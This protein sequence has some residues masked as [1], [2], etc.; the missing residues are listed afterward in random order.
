M[1]QPQTCKP[2][3]APNLIT[4]QPGGVPAIGQLER[5]W[6]SAVPL[7]QHMAVVA[8]G[9]VKQ[10][11]G[12][13]PQA[14]WAVEWMEEFSVSSSWG[15]GSRIAETAGLDTSATLQ[16][17]KHIGAGTAADKAGTHAGKATAA[18]AVPHAGVEPHQH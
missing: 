4:A 8:V 16:L 18:T 12:L 13:V 9:P 7:I 15:R 3:C 17:D 14:A 5:A 2:R 6:L 11:T 1:L 10:L